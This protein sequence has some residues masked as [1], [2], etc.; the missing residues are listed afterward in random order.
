MS[1]A[2]YVDHMLNLGAHLSLYVGQNAQQ[3]MADTCQSAVTIPSMGS[4]VKPMQPFRTDNQI[5]TL[6]IA[7]IMIFSVKRV[8]RNQLIL[9]GIIGLPGVSVRGA[10]GM[11]YSIGVAL[12]RVV[13]ALAMHPNQN[14][15]ELLRVVLQLGGHGLPGAS[16]PSLAARAFS[17]EPALAPNVIVRETHLSQNHA[18][19]RAVT[20]HFGGWVRECVHQTLASTPMVLAPVERPRPSAEE[21][22][23]EDPI[24]GDTRRL[25][26][27]QQAVL[28]RATCMVITIAMMQALV[29]SKLAEQRR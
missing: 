14:L 18:Q 8:G 15:V 3:T 29:G 16:V 26:L 19:L 2:T 17:E 24:V 20:F 11:A 21:S 22:A 4:F 23:K 1:F 6:T 5:T 9:L 27:L 12:A 10:V 25:N 13:A 7:D 28:E